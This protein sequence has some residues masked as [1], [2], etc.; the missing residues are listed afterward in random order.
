LGLGVPTAVERQYVPR[1]LCPNVLFD[2]SSSNGWI[3]YL[4]GLTLEAV[5]KQALAVLGPDRLL[6]GRDSSF[7]PRGWVRDVHAQQSNAL[8]TPGVGG[9]VKARI[10]GGN[11][12][13]VFP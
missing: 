4:P 13:R 1:F 3:K 8:D 6:F 2:P 11:F 10:F 7:F 12:D 5:F 9:D